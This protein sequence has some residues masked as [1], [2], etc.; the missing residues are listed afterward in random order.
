MINSLLGCSIVLILV[1]TLTRVSSH[2]PF[3]PI[4]PTLP[5]LPILPLWPICSSEARTWGTC[6]SYSVVADGASCHHQAPVAVAVAVAVAAA[7]AFAVVV[8][9]AVAVV[10]VVVF[11]AAVSVATGRSLP[12]P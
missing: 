10:A 9:V 2:I 3:L 4:L 7:A 1:L 5:I 6:G 8:A 11:V 12:T